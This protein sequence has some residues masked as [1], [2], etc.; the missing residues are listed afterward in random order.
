MQIES[1]YNFVP[2]AFKFKF[3]SRMNSPADNSKKL[4]SAISPELGT[5][6]KGKKL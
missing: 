1:Y 4:R 3:W 5:L 6:S 2:S